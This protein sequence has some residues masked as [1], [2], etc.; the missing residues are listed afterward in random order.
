[1]NNTVLVDLA[2]RFP[3]LDID[4]KYATDDNLTG[5]AI[6]PRA[7]CLL[8]RDAAQAL[9]RCLEVAALAGLRLRVFDAFRPRA[10]QEALWAVCP[11]PRYVTDPR[12]GS[13][14]NR[15]T[16]IDLTLLDAQGEP[17]DMGTEFDDMRDLA[18]AFHPALPPQVQR[19]RLCLNA[20]MAAGGFIGLATE[21][22]HFSLPPSARYPLLEAVTPALEPPA[23]AATDQTATGALMAGCGS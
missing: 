18:H 7:D 6:Y 14:H 1:M 22:W 17:L 20:V 16:A 9:G 19:N 8:H 15:G 13:S 23:S 10:A 2:A 21:W 5:R 12:V 3:Q 11:D 4:L